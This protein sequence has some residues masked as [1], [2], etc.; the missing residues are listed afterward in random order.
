MPL[1]LQNIV[2]LIMKSQPR[3]VPAAPSPLLAGSPPR[4]LAPVP[5][6]LLALNFTEGWFCFLVFFF[7]FF[8]IFFLSCRTISLISRGSEPA[9]RWFYPAWHS[10]HF[11]S[12]ENVELTQKGHKSGQLALAPRTSLVPLVRASFACIPPLKSEMS[13]HIALMVV[14]RD[15]PKVHLMKYTWPA[16]L[17]DCGS[18]APAPARGASPDPAPSRL[19][20]LWQT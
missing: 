3:E 1:P 15:A 8:P 20:A 4:L 9:V 7:F 6:P 14:R 12:D 11:I 10:F 5:L 13:L 16:M 18:R 17:L 2:I 19:R